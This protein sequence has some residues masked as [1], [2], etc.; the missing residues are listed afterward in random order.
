M[1]LG[2]VLQTVPLCRPKAR[3][4]MVS[5]A[6]YGLTTVRRTDD[7]RGP[8]CPGHVIDVRGES[9]ICRALAGEADMSALTTVTGL[10]VDGVAAV[11]RCA[12]RPTP[13]N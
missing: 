11:G 9:A 6:F 4:T 1:H 12:A 7:L 10:R 5:E 2:M 3:I 8:M 13:G